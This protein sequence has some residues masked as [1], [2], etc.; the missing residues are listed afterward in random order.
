MNCGCHQVVP[1]HVP[2]LRF[3]LILDL[4]NV[5]NQLDVPNTRS[6]ISAAGGLPDNDLAWPPPRRLRCS[7]RAR[8]SGNAARTGGNQNRNVANDKVANRGRLPDQRQHVLQNDVTL[9]SCRRP[10]M[11]PGD[12]GGSRVGR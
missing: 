9:H 5:V 10:P 4:N 7:D 2:T 1:C 12:F 8:D 3:T 6:F 11:Q